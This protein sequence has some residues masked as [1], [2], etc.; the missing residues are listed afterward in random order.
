MLNAR[1]TVEDFDMN[2]TFI[3]KN[4]SVIVETNA[5]HHNPD[6]WKNPEHFD[7]ERFA[8][9]GEHET[10]HEGMAWYDDNE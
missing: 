8:P 2:G 6:V 1:K 5:L 10:S 7:P 4:T 3:P 9:G